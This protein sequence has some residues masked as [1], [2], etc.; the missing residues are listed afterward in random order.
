MLHRDINNTPSQTV[1]RE[2]KEN[3]QIAKVNKMTEAEK[4]KRGWNQT[5]EA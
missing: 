5:R 1:V 3:L 2:Y 4:E